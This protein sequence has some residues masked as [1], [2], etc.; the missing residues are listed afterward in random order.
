MSGTVATYA[1]AR[2]GTPGL[3]PGSESHLG[4]DRLSGVAL[5]TANRSQDASAPPG[6]G[7]NGLGLG[8]LRLLG[9][10]TPAGASRRRCHLGGG[11]RGCARAPR[12]PAGGRL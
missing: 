7:P 11:R 1:T 5:R 12:G 8:R 3:R 6:P 9:R 10:P 2:E 4:A